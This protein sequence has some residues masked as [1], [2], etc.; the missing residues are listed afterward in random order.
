MKLQVLG[1]DYGTSLSIKKISRRTTSYDRPYKPGRSRLLAG[2][3]CDGT[4]LGGNPVSAIAAG[5][6]GSAAGAAVGVVTAVGSVIGDVIGAVSSWSASNKAAAI[7]QDVSNQQK[8]VA[9]LN[10]T[11]T[12]DRLWGADY[13][14]KNPSFYSV[15]LQVMAVSVHG[16]AGF[17]GVAYDDPVCMANV[18]VELQTPGIT[19]MKQGI[20]VIIYS[21]QGY[22]RSFPVL[23]KAASAYVQSKGQTTDLSLTAP[24]ATAAVIAAK[25]QPPTLVQSAGPTVAAKQG[26]AVTPVTAGM[27][28]GNNMMMIYLIGGSLLAVVYSLV[29]KKKKG[30]RSR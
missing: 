4:M 2:Y 17:L 28:G 6:K 14:I 13:I 15:D 29:T 12:R 10:S 11:S 16:C 23:V 19:A 8:A 9:F 3:S 25:V 22:Y 26:A 7:A 5:A 21:N 30:R 27:F 24:P 18:L 20:A 1:D